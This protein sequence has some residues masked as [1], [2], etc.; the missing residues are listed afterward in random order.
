M[1]VIID[2]C[3][4]FRYKF[5]RKKGNANRKAHSAVFRTVRSVQKGLRVWKY[6]IK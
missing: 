6:K 1:F 5:L 4:V 3:G 2:I